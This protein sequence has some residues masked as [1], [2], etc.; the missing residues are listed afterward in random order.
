MK[1]N[2]KIIKI[3]SI[4]FM[5]FLIIFLTMCNL[6][7]NVDEANVV[8]EIIPPGISNIY[9]HTKVGG[10]SWDRAYSIQ[11]TSDSGYIVSGYSNSS[12]IQD[13]YRINMET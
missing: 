5:I 8:D 9:W 12:D 6:N 7:D 13:S 4:P 2:L 10:N 1:I 11:Q 3:G